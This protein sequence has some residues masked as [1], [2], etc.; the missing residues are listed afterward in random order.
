MKR[1]F[2]FTLIELMITVAL[3][4]LL[5][6][7]GVPSFLGAVEQNNLAT[8]HNLMVS[9][10]NMAR[11]EAVK[12]GQTVTLCKSTD[13]STCSTSD[14]FDDGWIVFVDESG[15]GSRASSEELLR[16][17]DAMDSGY[18]FE[19]DG[20]YIAYLPT[21]ELVTNSA[22][23]MLLCKDSSTSKARALYINATGRIHLGR[24]TDN[25]KIPEDDSGTDITSCSP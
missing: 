17:Q 6:T 24:D 5:L 12:R 9:S 11:S 7:L 15:I 23:E 22:N 10:I 3:L 25:N 13:G 14:D 4:A 2:G 8:K 18:S 21:G 19:G 1:N 20:D 16:V